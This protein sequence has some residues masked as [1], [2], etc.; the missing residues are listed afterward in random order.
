MALAPPSIRHKEHHMKKQLN[1]TLSGLLG[2]ASL[3]LMLASPAAMADTLN[4][5]TFSLGPLGSTTMILPNATITSFGS[6]I[7][8][9]AAGL[10]HEICALTPGN[11][12]EADMKIAFTSSV[13]N[14]SFVTSGYNP[15]DFINVSAYNGL[16]LLGSVGHSSNGLVDLTAWSGITSIFIDDSSTGAGFA[17]DHFNFNSAAPVPEP[18]TYA[19]MLAGLGMLGFMARRRKLKAA[20]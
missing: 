16:T 5:N 2:A 18:E 10:D 4:F 13:S 14:L 8:V 17:Y 9:G 7:Y 20:A 6:N 12:C 19:M 11:D 15:G 3:G 1:K